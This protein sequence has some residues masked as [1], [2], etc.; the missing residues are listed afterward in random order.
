MLDIANALMRA[1][2]EIVR[3]PSAPGG[4]AGSGSEDGA[5]VAV[6][7]TPDIAADLSTQ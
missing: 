1:S 3:G 4:A 7:A 5:P 2:T 6:P